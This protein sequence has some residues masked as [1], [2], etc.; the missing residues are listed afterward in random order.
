MDTHFSVLIIED[1]P[2]MARSLKEALANERFVPDW[3]AT[4]SDQAL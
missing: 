4:G 1:D 2:A 3:A